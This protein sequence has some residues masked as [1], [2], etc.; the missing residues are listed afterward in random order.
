MV[1]T[2][3][4]RAV[5]QSMIADTYG[6]DTVYAIKYA[7][8]NSAI[9]KSGVSQ[10]LPPLVQTDGSTTITVPV[11][12]FGDWALAMGGDGQNVRMTVPINQMMYDDGSVVTFDGLT[13]TIEVCLEFIPQRDPALYG[14]QDDAEWMELKIATTPRGDNASGSAVTVLGLTCSGS[15]CPSPLQ[16][17]I[18]ESLLGNWFNVD[19]N[20]KEFNHVFAAVNLN[21]KAGVDTTDDG[22]TND[23]R[24]LKP[25]M[26]G[27]AVAD[28]TSLA[29]SVFAV[30]ATTARDQG[31]PA[32]DPESL[33][34]RVSAN[35][36]PEGK[37][38]A[39]LLS[40][41]RYLKKLLLPGAGG[42]FT[43][44]IKEEA[45]KTWPTDYF[46]LED[47]GTTI[48]NTKD[49]FIEKLDIGD[50]EER[51]EVKAGNFAVHLRDECLEVEFVDMHHPFS[52]FLFWVDVFHSIRSQAV[53]NLEVVDAQDADGNPI[54]KTMFDLTPSTAE[55]AVHSHDVIA[56]KS[57]TTQWVQIGLL[58][59]TLLF[60]II[61]LGQAFRLFR[62][63][64]AAVKLSGDTMQAANL[65]RA[66]T[67]APLPA[68]EVVQAAATGANAA[69]AAVSGSVASRNMLSAIWQIYRT[70]LFATV[71]TGLGLLGGSIAL[72]ES[73]ANRRA[74]GFLPDFD[75]FASNVMA[76]V[77]WP[78]QES[79]FTP[80]SV[81]FNGSFQISGNP[82]FA[83]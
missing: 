74:Q 41:E 71:G 1:K 47:S 51:A 21:D 62:A 10:T 27:Y 3:D 20:L 57:P 29:D 31:E 73:I 25:D 32:P 37:R 15:V 72:L 49:V 39:F 50:S 18:I 69:L 55:D 5:A 38:S 33:F 67:T 8:V 43:G 13:A 76:P 65:A 14:A 83:D 19:D 63:G 36:I 12:E 78:T 22:E 6:W 82:D 45:G 34:H 40:K 35:A 61:G 48:R 66:A 77:R 2:I 59:A 44:P 4:R 17:A 42:F 9:A 58:S 70:T 75:H 68:P 79:E 60:T 30:L 64:E 24:W 81:C 7:D 56:V 28:G 46:E 26:L 54:K 53:P 52:G 80:D 11:G 23:F 16:T